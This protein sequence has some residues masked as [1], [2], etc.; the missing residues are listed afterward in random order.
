MGHR[1][2][3]VHNIIHILFG[4]RYLIQHPFGDCLIF[5]DQGHETLVW[6]SSLPDSISK[7]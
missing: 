3:V 2:D 7:R 5:S 6:K 4:Q 1:T